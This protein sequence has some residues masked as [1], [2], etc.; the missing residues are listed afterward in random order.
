MKGN[1]ALQ[2]NEKRLP[3]FFVVTK[4]NEK[5]P[6][7]Y[8]VYCSFVTSLYGKGGGAVSGTSFQS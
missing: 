4:V 6:F 2:Q 7:I 3:T 5:V 8:S 1:D